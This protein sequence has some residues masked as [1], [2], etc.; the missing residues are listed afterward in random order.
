MARASF[1]MKR[2]KIKQ[3][4]VATTDGASSKKKTNIDLAAMIRTSHEDPSQMMKYEYTKTHY[5]SKFIIRVNNT[6][7]VTKVLL[8]RDPKASQD[9]EAHTQTMVIGKIKA[10]K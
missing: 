7:T 10:S 8:N 2:E 9:L 5:V 3:K 1:E 6:L 4:E